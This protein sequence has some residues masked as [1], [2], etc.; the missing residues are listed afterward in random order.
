MNVWD[1]VIL[2]AV[3]G[4]VFAA[5]KVLRGKKKEENGGCSCGCAGCQRNCPVKKQEASDG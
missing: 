2:G 5:V 1:W 3:G 4:L